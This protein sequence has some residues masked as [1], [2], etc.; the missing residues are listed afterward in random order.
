MIEY[1]SLIVYVKQN[2]SICK[3]EWYWIWDRMIANARENSCLYESLMVNV[4]EFDWT[5]TEFDWN[6]NATEFSVPDWLIFVQEGVG[7]PF[8]HAEDMEERQWLNEAIGL[9]KN[10]LTYPT[11]VTAMSEFFDPQSWHPST[12]VTSNAAIDVEMQR[13]F[14]AGSGAPGSSTSAGASLH[15]N[16]VMGPC[17]QTWQYFGGWTAKSRKRWVPLTM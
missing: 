8:H 12:G 16:H 17:Y 1:V 9:I 13:L 4:R 2:N 14:R 15:V 6:R 7:P 11:V 5:G 10:I 3:R